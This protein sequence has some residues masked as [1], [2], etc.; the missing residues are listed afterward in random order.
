MI[1]YNKWIEDDC[2]DFFDGSLIQ[3]EY[4]FDD[5]N[6]IEYWQNY[7]EYG[8]DNDAIIYNILS[9][10]FTVDGETDYE[11][12]DLDYELY[13]EWF[14]NKNSAK[15]FAVAVDKFRCYCIKK[16]KELKDKIDGQ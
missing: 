6:S 7:C 11:Y 4:Y 13:I 16:Y 10:Y 5:K 2:S 1:E 14:D 3:Y 9:I 15:E 8:E 12:E